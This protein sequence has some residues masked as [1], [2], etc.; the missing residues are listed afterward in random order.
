[1]FIN[2]GTLITSCEILLVLTMHA[3][4]ELQFLDDFIPQTPGEGFA[5]GPR[6]GLC[7]KHLVI[8]HI[9]GTPMHF[10]H[11]YWYQNIQRHLGVNEFA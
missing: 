7:P 4:K 1:M 9:P 5:H 8:V 11:Q 6:Y 10:L 2:L 3:M